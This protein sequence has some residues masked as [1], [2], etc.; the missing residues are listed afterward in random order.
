MSSSSQKNDSIPLVKQ[1]RKPASQICNYSL[2]SGNENEIKLHES[3]LLRFGP[4]YCKDDDR[5]LKDDAWQHV[6]QKSPDREAVTNEIYLGAVRRV[7]K[8]ARETYA[9]DDKVNNLTGS[10][11]RWM[12]IKDGCL[13]LQLALFVLGG[14][15]QLGYSPDHKIFGKKADLS[16]WIRSMFFV[17]NQI[18][19]VVL[20]ELMKQSFFQQVIIAHNQGKWD[21]PKDNL[22]KIVLYQLLL[23]P[24]TFDINQQ[25]R[26]ESNKFASFL[27]GL[28]IKRSKPNPLLEAACDVLHGLHSFIVGPEIE[29]NDANN[30]DEE[31]AEEEDHDYFDD[32][33]AQRAGGV[34]EQQGED[35][36][37]ARFGPILPIADEE[38]F[39]VM[40]NIKDRKFSSATKLRQAGIH[41]KLI[42]DKGSRSI[43]LSKNMMRAY[44]SLPP[45]IVDEYTKILFRS[46]KEYEIIQQLGENE[47]RSYLRFISELIRTP[48]DVKELAKKGII[49]GRQKHKDK[50]PDILGRL[51]PRDIYNQHFR[52]VKIKVND[53]A[54]PPW[55]Y[56][57]KYV[58]LVVVLTMIQTV[59]AILSYHHSKK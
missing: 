4:F 31:E 7:E 41:Y 45:F 40:G 15:K 53:Y 21:Q 24:P 33:E 2:G 19:L 39:I 48:E 11:F 46:L 9:D 35:H 16:G 59:Y 37:G 50:L 23:V 27:K 17:G 54:R 1:A 29:S 12:M 38:E 55:A 36:E 52:L 49:R 56:L 30:D 57:K 26:F 8:Q 13:F 22:C 58:E 5:S 51:A 32:L 20:R 25:N 10:Q 34:V 6:V 44:L 42:E 3:L 14:S 47:T 18:P 28:L 43:I